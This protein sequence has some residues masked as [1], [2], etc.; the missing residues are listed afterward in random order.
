VVE[1]GGTSKPQHDLYR[2]VSLHQSGSGRNKH[3]CH[4]SN[5]RDSC[6]FEGWG[7]GGLGAANAWVCT[8]LIGACA[9]RRA[10]LRRRTL[11]SGR[12][13]RRRG[14]AHSRGGGARGGGVRGGGARGGGRGAGRAEFNLHTAQQ[15][16]T[17]ACKFPLGRCSGAVAESLVGGACLQSSAGN[18]SRRSG[19]RRIMLKATHSRAAV[20]QAIHLKSSLEIPDYQEPAGTSKKKLVTRAQKRDTVLY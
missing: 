9:R 16:F 5:D 11:S 3:G 6:T 13:T 7:A 18:S 1:A 20:W 4:A 12:R 19:W 14:R 15:R 8:G 2:V 10:C 17:H